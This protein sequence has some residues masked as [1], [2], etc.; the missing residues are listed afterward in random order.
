MFGKKTN[1]EE[2][3][4]G[5]LPQDAGEPLTITG[6]ADENAEV[7][8]IPETIDGKLAAGHSLTAAVLRASTCPMV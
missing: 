8:K 4:A 2:R 1:R 6:Y 7:L 5:R 3:L